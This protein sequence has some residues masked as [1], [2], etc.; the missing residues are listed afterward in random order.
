MNKK[1]STKTLE[2]VQLSLFAALIVIMAFTPFLGYIP[3]VFTMATLI[4]IPVIIGSLLLGP[5]KGSI[6]GALF[7]LTS[8]LNA[9]FNPVPTSFV[10]SPFYSGGNFCS[11]I[12]AF[13]PR[14]LIGIVP[15][16]VYKLIVGLIHKKDSTFALVVA[17]LAGS[18][19]NTLLVMNFIYIFFAKSYA[20]A[21]GRAFEA[22]YQAILMIICINGIPEA[23]IAAIIV[24]AVCKVM[25]KIKVGKISVQTVK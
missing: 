21:S 11:L 23:I 19:T 25:I 14:I 3:L 8:L 16:Y 2:L 17:G 4:H 20:Q 1:Q 10:F 24:T 15:Y 5:K 12:I 7:G 18:L 6:L 22:L 9:T 13:V